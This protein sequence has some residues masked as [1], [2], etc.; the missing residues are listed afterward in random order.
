MAAFYNDTD[1]YAAQWLR[2]L[3][4]KGLIPDG[5]VSTRSIIDLRP[6]DLAGFTQVHLFAGIGGWA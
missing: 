2:N 6:A 5:E 3:I 1:E 4:K